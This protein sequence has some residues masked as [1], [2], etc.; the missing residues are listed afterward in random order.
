M[1]SLGGQFLLLLWKNYKLQSR[2]KILTLFEIITPLFF[3]TILV[4]IRT[5]METEYIAEYTLASPEELP[6]RYSS[7]SR[8]NLFYAPTN[9][10][11]TTTVSYVAQQLSSD[12]K[13][14]SKYVTT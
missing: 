14:K 7:F 11:T 2:R 5:F 13:V 10:F 6:N 3:A 4:L 9:N 1:A 12:E 8:K